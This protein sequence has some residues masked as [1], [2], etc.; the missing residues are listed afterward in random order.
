MCVYWSLDRLLSTAGCLFCLSVCRFRSLLRIKHT[1]LC[2]YQ[3]QWHI[4]FPPVRVQ[5]QGHS[6][7]SDGEEVSL[8]VL[9]SV[10]IH[11]S[12]GCTF[13][14]TVISTKLNDNDGGGG[15]DS[16]LVTNSVLIA[17]DMCSARENTCTTFDRLTSTFPRLRIVF[18]YIHISV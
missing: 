1:G 12:C 18:C 15:G 7:A 6:E 8:C 11:C 16:T 10:W 14:S 4:Q 2:N 3:C 13:C 9:C 17:S 5:S